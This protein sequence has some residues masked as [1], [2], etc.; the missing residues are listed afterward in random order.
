MREYFLNLFS[1]SGYPR[2]WD[3]GDWSDFAGWFH[4]LSDLGTWAA[5]TAIPLTLFFFVRRRRDIPFSRI[6]LLF[7]AFILACGTVHLI[8]AIIFWYPIYRIQGV[9]KFITAVVSWGTIVALVRILPY[10]LTLPGV[11]KLNQQ[12]SEEVDHRRRSE[13]ASHEQRMFTQAVLDSLTSHICVLD[14]EGVIIAVNDSWDRFAKANGGVGETGFGVGSNYLSVVYKAC[15]SAD[16]ASAAPVVLDGLRDLLAGNSPSFSA[17][18]PCHSPTEQRWF[19][20]NAAPLQTEVGGAV[21]SHADITHRKLLELELAQSRKDAEKANQAKS[22]FLASMSHEIRTPM[23]AI[24]GCAD[25][26]FPQ[27]E[28]EEQR[29]MLHMLRGQGYLLLGLLND[30]LD[31]SKIEAGKLDIHYEPSSLV[32]II[33]E[34]RSLM[35]VLASEKGIEIGTVFET[36]IPDLIST[37]PLRLRQ[38]LMNLLSNAVKFTMEGSVTI[39]VRCEAQGDES[40]LVLRVRD[41]GMGIS[42]E[43]KL[44]IF[45]A[46][47]QGDSAVTRKYGG[48]GLGLTICQRLTQMLHGSIDVNSHPGEGAE[49]TVRL[50]LGDLGD[51]V[52]HD[53]D[54]LPIRKVSS[55]DS[56]LRTALM[57]CRVLVAEDTRGIQFMIRRMLEGQVDTVTVVDNGEEAVVELSRGQQ[58]GVPYDIVLMDM[59]MPVLNGFDATARLRARG[60]QQPIIALTAAAMHGDRE[61]CLRVGC[62]D[63]VPKPI[64]RQQLL[65]TISK[66]YN[67]LRNGEE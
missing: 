9:V 34:V 29:E 11:A 13:K 67:L 50:P 65:L 40:W 38:I 30:I 39:F 5:Y 42:D 36:R 58:E 6:F 26:L 55:S 41:T 35:D 54:T 31:V 33:S 4:V 62:N 44:A 56:Q 49:F 57:P 53:A 10:A 18:Y 64:D 21:V 15:E 1:T 8:E 19:L 37:D 17:E 20:L 22:E 48:T 47:T 3:C 46:F 25:L 43:R 52:L 24:L 2:R 45:Q 60:F 28:D 51:D 63:Y 61:K 16:G 12:L 7:G 23:T 27:L 32:E 59:Q 66:H 14:R